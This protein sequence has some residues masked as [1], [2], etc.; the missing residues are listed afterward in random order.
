[1]AQD[2]TPV[3]RTK[4]IP[5]RPGFQVIQASAWCH[6]QHRESGISR[7]WQ[8]ELAGPAIRAGQHEQDWPDGACERAYRPPGARRYPRP[9]AADRREC[10]RGGGQTPGVWLA[11]Y[12]R[13]RSSSTDVP[14]NMSESRTAARPFPGPGH[15]SWPDV[16]D[17]R[18]LS[19]S[20]QSPRA[21]ARAYRVQ[22]VAMGPSSYRPVALR[23]APA[24]LLPVSGVL[25]SC[26]SSLR[27]SSPPSR[28]APWL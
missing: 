11:Q 3:R 1:M 10:L 15:T 5:A 24:C 8:A 27:P 19:G 22:E 6:G 25:R 18:P 28:P 13:R 17:N 2:I 21:A 9:D 16:P 14:D 26:R 4:D 12:L 23:P 7:F 20:S